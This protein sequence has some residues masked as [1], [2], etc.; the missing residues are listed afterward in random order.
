[1]ATIAKP[2]MAIRVAPTNLKPGELSEARRPGQTDLM[3][4]EGGRLSSLFQNIL[5][6][7]ASIEVALRRMSGDSAR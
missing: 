4:T 6:W 2:V 5:E 7:R 1:L 3:L